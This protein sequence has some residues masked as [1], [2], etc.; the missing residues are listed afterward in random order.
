MTG[1]LSICNH[2]KYCITK[3]VVVCFY[4]LVVCLKKKEKRRHPREYT[5]IKKT[6]KI[7]YILLK[8]MT[9]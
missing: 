6:T 3:G 7:A 8:K 5:F 2:A 4:I 9:F 1:Q